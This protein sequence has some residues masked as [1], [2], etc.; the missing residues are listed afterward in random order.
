MSGDSRKQFILATTG[1]YFAIPVTDAAFVKQ[2]HSAALNS[3]LDDGNTNI[4]AGRLDPR[5]RTKNV[6]FSDKVK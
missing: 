5:S 4:L 2:A 1:N 3:F 6:I